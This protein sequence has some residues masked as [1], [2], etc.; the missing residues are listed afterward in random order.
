MK[1]AADAVTSLDLPSPLLPH[2]DSLLVKLTIIMSSGLHFNWPG[3]T[4]ASLFAGKQNVN[5]SAWSKCTGST[6]FL[7]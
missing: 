5:S 4:L 3:D 6:S 1:A 2:S 7:F